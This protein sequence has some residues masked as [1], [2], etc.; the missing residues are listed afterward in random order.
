VQAAG[1]A[2]LSN[3]GAYA[4][5]DR[6]L[7]FDQN[8][9]DETLPGPW[10]WDVKRLAASL[11]IAGE[12]RG[13]DAT[14]NRDI[15]RGAVAAYQDAMR[16]FAE[17]RV[18]DLWYDRLDTAA[19]TAAVGPLATGPDAATRV[20]RFDAK[21]RT[22]DHLQALRKLTVE[23]DGRRQIRHDPPILLRLRDVPELT[24]TDLDGVALE[25]LDRYATSL[26]DDKRH[27]YE[28]F[29]PIDVALKVVGVGSVG[30]RCLIVLFEGRDH[31]DPLFLQVKEAGPSVLEAHLPASRY[32]HHGRRV[33]EGQRL[34]QATS[35][36]FL[37]WTSGPEGRHFYVRQLRDW[38]G[39]VDVGRMDAHG[40]AVRP[41]VRHHAGTGP[42][43][44]RRGRRHRRL[45]RQRCQPSHVRSPAS[46]RHTPS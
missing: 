32:H 33:V 2:H 7:V 36:I 39:S 45:P 34:V 14:H 8:D 15:A 6:T 42:C 11:V 21:A 19:V 43:P 13:F 4:S 9:F 29:R 41:P 22:R 44:H 28:R 24:G 10:E 17:M 12:D 38:K 1:D 40:L 23:V 26:P 16:R 30:T 27:L 37:G 46:L 18:L 31:D 3:F 20:A 35:D 5:P 25:V